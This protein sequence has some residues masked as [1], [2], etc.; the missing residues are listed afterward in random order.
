MTTDF[1][2][3][4]TNE[5]VNGDG[6]DLRNVQEQQQQLHSIL[7]RFVNGLFVI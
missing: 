2:E 5:C 6:V 1:I 3:F 7:Y 4:E